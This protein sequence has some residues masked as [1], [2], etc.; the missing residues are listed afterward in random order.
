MCEPTG[1]TWRPIVD[2]EG[3][4]EVSDIGRVR[5]VFL[6]PSE[7]YRV[8]RPSMN[9]Y[10]YPTV[11]LSRPGLV[12]RRA[13]HVLVA[14]AFLGPRLHGMEVCHNDGNSANAALTNLRYDTRSGNERDKIAHG[15]HAN[16]RK[17]H[18]KRDHEF[19]PE[20]TYLTVQG[21]RECRTCA[22]YREAIYA[23]AAK[24]TRVAKPHPNKLKTHCPQD[25]E[26]TEENTYRNP[27]SGHRMCR[28][29][30]RERNRAVRAAE[31]AKR[32]A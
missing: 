10:G 25:H 1:E 18:C 24:A 8:M 27:A 19:T 7:G 13:I 15:T 17:T 14:K 20:N 23:E 29:C 12:V 3:F 4:Y 28:T 11:G 31:R 30:M 22:R 5:R 32:A 21:A 2:W 6:P 16:A 26:Y 9:Q